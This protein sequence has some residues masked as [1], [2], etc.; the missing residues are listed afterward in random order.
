MNNIDYERRLDEILDRLNMHTLDC[1]DPECSSY[2]LVLRE[3]SNHMDFMTD[4]KDWMIRC[5]NAA[6]DTNITACTRHAFQHLVHT[7]NDYWLCPDCFNESQTQDLELVM[8]IIP[9]SRRSS[10]NDYWYEQTPIG[11]V[12]CTKS[13]CI[14][15]TYNK[16]LLT[17]Y[18]G[19]YNQTR[20]EPKQV[21]TGQKG[22]CSKVSKN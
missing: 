12:K 13:E 6:C 21:L 4:Y 22:V 18:E 9:H 2:Q 16:K 11:L 20:T 17:D 7:C 3:K 5:Q 8:E 14:C 19:V 15:K 10:T 1:E